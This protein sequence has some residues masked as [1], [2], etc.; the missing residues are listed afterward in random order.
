MTEK[1]LWQRWE[2]LR[3]AGT[4]MTPATTA[5][6]AEGLRRLSSAET[7]YLERL[8]LTDFR[9]FSQ[10]SVTFDR[11]L[12]VF[13]GENG[14]GK[15]TLLDAAGKAL[16]WVEAGII[17]A[18]SR[19]SAISEDDIR[20]SDTAGAPADKAEAA[21]TFS[22]DR[23]TIPG[24]LCKRRRGTK[25]SSVSDLRNL[26]SVGEMFRT[27]RATDSVSRPLFLYFAASRG[28]NYRDKV[29]QGEFASIGKRL[30][31]VYLGTEAYDR[32][33]QADKSPAQFLGWLAFYGKRARF[34]PETA[35]REAAIRKLS[36]VK[37]AVRSFW[38]ECTDIR[39][40]AADGWDQ[41]I[42][43]RNGVP[44]QHHQLSD[45]ERMVFFLFGEI[46]WRLTELNPQGNAA[47]GSGIVLIDEIELHLHPQWQLT[48]I[49]SLRKTFPNLQFIITT[50][51][52]QVLTTVRRECIRNLPTHIRSVEDLQSPAEQTRSLSS[53]EI[54]ETV[55]DTASAPTQFEESRWLADCQAAILARR[56]PKAQALFK[57]A[58]DYFGPRNSQVMVLKAML[59]VAEK[60][61]EEQR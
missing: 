43:E 46:A 29:S 35:E 55:M 15:S 58:S 7:L 33:V 11:N 40:D 31:A 34:H 59:K 6:L 53:N 41:I 5:E 22:L 26:Q 8:K 56:L 32:A 28:G 19:G 49:E 48:V 36:Q 47:E 45:G 20:L 4:E 51:S 24:V 16:S 30:D 57:K 10:L 14:R 13:H 38:P 60:A 61:V 50:H 52:P 3:Q 21:V 25:G 37:D 18:N 39:W 42:V 27:L 44:L 1:S 12:T 9:C 54:L 2:T 23:A 17:G